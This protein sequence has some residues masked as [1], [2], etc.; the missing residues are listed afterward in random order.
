MLAWHQEKLAI[1]NRS[2]LALLCV[3][4]PCKLEIEVC[5]RIHCGCFTG[6]HYLGKLKGRYK[7]TYLRGAV[8]TQSGWSWNQALQ[9]HCYGNC[10]QPC[11]G[12]FLGGKLCP[13]FD[14]TGFSTAEAAEEYWK[15][16]YEFMDFDGT[17]DIYLRYSDDN[18]ADS[19]G[20]ITY[21]LL[22]VSDLTEA[23]RQ[24]TMLPKEL[25]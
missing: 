21:S 14:A 4:C 18:C 23:Q 6:G 22:K 24:I 11:F 8:V 12:I 16:S 7:I 20:C 25:Q 10:E 9:G 17:S 5:A 3:S 13:G 19:L 2:A 15:K 1:M